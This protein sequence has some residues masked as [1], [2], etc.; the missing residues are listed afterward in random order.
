MT[1]KTKVWGKKKK[2]KKK[3]QVAWRGNAYQAQNLN[4]EKVSCTQASKVGRQGCS[5]I[6]CLVSGWLLRG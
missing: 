5:P 6:S 2:G 1:L 4:N 3:I